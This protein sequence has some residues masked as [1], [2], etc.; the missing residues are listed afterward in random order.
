MSCVFFTPYAPAVRTPAAPMLTN[1][2]VEHAKTT[3]KAVN[4][5]ST[6]VQSA[7]LEIMTNH[8][9]TPLLIRIRTLWTRFAIK[10]GRA[11]TRVV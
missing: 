8:D 7:V 6:A 11:P 1:L 3:T 5:A 10:R 9:A 4:G 2:L